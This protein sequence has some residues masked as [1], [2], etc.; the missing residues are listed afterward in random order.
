MS[1]A[2]LIGDP[3]DGVLWLANYRAACGDG[4]RAGQII[5]TGSLTG[6]QMTAPG[7]HVMADFGSL[8][9]VELQLLA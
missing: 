4:M 7:D 9:T 8:G 2:E 5:S 1:V 3:L 6:V